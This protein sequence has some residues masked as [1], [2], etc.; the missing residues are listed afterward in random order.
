[1]KTPAY[2]VVHFKKV[3]GEQ[4]FVTSAPMLVK[5]MVVVDD[6]IW[7]MFTI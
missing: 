6:R 3:K 5:L 1:M 2:I 7:Y 4:N